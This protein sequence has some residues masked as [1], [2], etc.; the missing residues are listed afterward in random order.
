M[1]SVATFFKGSHLNF[2][3][4]Y[5]LTTSM[6]YKNVLGPIVQGVWGPWL[7]VCKEDVEP[8]SYGS[9]ACCQA[10]QHRGEFFVKLSDRLEKIS[11]YIFCQST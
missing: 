3:H 7:I 9:T 11:S 6:L 4:I 2:S 10:A 1:N 8:I 5:D